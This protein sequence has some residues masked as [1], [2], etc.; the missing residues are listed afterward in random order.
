MSIQVKELASAIDSIQD[1]IAQMS[2]ELA[3][4]KASVQSYEAQQK[5]A[6]LAEYLDHQINDELD[7]IAGD[8]AWK[9]A[10][11]CMRKHNPPEQRRKIILE[12]EKPFDP[13]E[14]P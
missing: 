2:K 11:E 6:I 12:F 8:D 3:E 14:N 13:K 4:L 1:H 5:R 7:R 10:I 9:E